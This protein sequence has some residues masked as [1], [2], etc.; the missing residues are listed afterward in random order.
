MLKPKYVFFFLLII[1][2]DIARFK[3]S[4]DQESL[5][6]KIKW[7][8]S[9]KITTKEE[10]LSR[11]KRLKNLNVLGV[12]LSVTT[13]ANLFWTK[14]NSYKLGLLAT[15]ILSILITNNLRTKNQFFKKNECNIKE[16]IEKLAPIVENKCSQIDSWIASIMFKENKINLNTLN[17]YFQ[18]LVE[19]ISLCEKATN[20]CKIPSN[21][22]NIN[23]KNLMKSLNNLIARTFHLLNNELSI[24][25]AEMY[26]KKNSQNTNPEPKPSP[27]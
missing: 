8:N 6:E 22:A 12:G 1:I 20:F 5:K 21:D 18:D 16:F 13:I 24:Q 14:K 10:Q 11:I 15:G 9:I 4:E 3:H 23:Q 27:H 7:L 2:H 17:Y 25:C 19:M 26:M